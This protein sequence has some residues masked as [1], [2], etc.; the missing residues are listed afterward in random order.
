MALETVPLD[1]GIFLGFFNRCQYDRNNQ[2]FQA[3]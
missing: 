2:N 3:S 1:L